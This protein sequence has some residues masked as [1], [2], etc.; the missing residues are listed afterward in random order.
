MERV[1]NINKEIYNEPYTRTR[2]KIKP[3]GTIDVY[4]IG[5]PEI[6]DFITR[7]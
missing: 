3:A 5:I 4:R 7:K 1:E 2:A 6:Q